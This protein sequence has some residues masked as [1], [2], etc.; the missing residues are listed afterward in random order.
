MRPGPSSQKL[1]GEGPERRLECPCARGSLEAAPARLQSGLRAPPAVPESRP[2]AQLCAA[3]AVASAFI[4][5]A[6]SILAPRG[7]QQSGD[8]ISKRWEGLEGVCVHEGGEAW[9]SPPALPGAAGPLAKLPSGRECR[10]VRARTRLTEARGGRNPDTGARPLHRGVRSGARKYFSEQGCNVLQK[11]F[12]SVSFTPL[13]AQLLC[14]VKSF[15]G[16]IQPNW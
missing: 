1:S 12:S 3:T 13:G 16:E 2:Q 4:P 5:R 7:R 11:H 14:T 15:R 10:G 9:P 6:P 8:G